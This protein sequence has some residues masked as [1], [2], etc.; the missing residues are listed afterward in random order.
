[1]FL[2]LGGSEL[3]IQR[4]IEKQHIDPRFPENAEG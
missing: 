1:M 3:L 2:L 4:Q